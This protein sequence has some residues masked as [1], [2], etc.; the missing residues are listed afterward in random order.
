MKRK[1]PAEYWIFGKAGYPVGYPVRPKYVTLRNILTKMKVGLVWKEENPARYWIFY[2]TGLYLI[3]G[4]ISGLSRICYLEEYDEHEGRIGVIRVSGRILNTP[5][6][7]TLD[8]RSGR[9]L[10]RISGT[11]LYITL[12]SMANM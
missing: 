7:R 5:P 6:D 1:Y 3:S 8:I 11:S 10:D 4:R 2:N 9:T 12:K